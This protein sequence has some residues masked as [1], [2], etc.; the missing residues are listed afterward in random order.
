M[1]L[2]PN[3]K[4]E[5]SNHEALCFYR[6][7]Q[8]LKGDIRRLE[9]DHFREVQRLEDDHAREVRALQD[10]EI[11]LKYTYEEKITELKDVHE[12]KIVERKDVYEEE[13]AELK[14][15]LRS[16]EGGIHDLDHPK[17]ALPS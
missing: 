8:E 6:H 3:W 12:E 7:V 9:D 2:C 14:Q 16:V 10:E 15:R 17:K 4:L 5:H 11:R 13:I 1:Y